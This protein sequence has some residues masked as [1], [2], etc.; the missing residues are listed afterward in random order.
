MANLE[1]TL[2]AAAEEAAKMQDEFQ[3]QIDNL[4]SHIYYVEG[5][6]SKLKKKINNAKDLFRQLADILEKDEIYD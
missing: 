5:E 4:N 6:N 2:R 3:Q 1:G